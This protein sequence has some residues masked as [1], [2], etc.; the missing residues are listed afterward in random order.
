MASGDGTDTIEMESVVST[1]YTDIQTS[2]HTKTTSD[3]DGKSEIK[4]T[5]SLFCLHRNFH[6]LSNTHT[7]R[8][9]ITHLINGGPGVDTFSKK[10][11]YLTQY[12]INNSFDYRPKILSPLKHFIR[13]IVIWF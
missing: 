10:K 4:K 11:K 1:K 7:E 6:H 13:V 5:N 3:D 12:Q 8:V 9:L 2:S